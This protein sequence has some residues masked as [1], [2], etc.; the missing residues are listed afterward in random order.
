MPVRKTGHDHNI[1]HRQAEKIIN[2]FLANTCYNTW[3]KGKEEVLYWKKKVTGERT[4]ENKDYDS[5]IYK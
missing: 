2:H 1:G 4:A 5:Y 3:D